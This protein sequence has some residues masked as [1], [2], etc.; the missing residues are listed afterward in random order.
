MQTNLIYAIV[1]AADLSR[2]RKFY[3]NLGLKAIAEDPWPGV[4]FE[5]GDGSLLYLYQTPNAGKAPHT[6]AGFS[7]DDVEATV[8]GLR[9]KGV[10]FEEYQ[11]PDLKT[12]NGIATVGPVKS[13]WFKDTEGNILAIDNMKS[14]LRQSHVRT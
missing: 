8:D 3:E 4:T 7:V 9:A 2:A 13:A 6:L 11:T 14:V 10:R 1:P 5:G 12:V